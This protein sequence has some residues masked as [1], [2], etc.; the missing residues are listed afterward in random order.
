MWPKRHGSAAKATA[1]ETL[2]AFGCARRRLSDVALRRRMP[3][4]GVSS[5]DFGPPLGRSFFC[6]ERLRERGLDPDDGY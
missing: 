2:L 4:L 5:L 6:P 1:A 3:F